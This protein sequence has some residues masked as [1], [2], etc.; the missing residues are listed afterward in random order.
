MDPTPAQLRG[1]EPVVAEI[2]ITMLN[3]ARAQGVP[4]VIVH[5]GGL[6]NQA[7]QA[8]L[9]GMGRSRTRDSA[10]LQGRAFDF[11]VLGIGRDQVPREL[12]QVLG[13]WGEELG[14]T[15]G[16]RWGWDWA[17]FELPK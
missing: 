6:R 12:W 2:A 10:H 13:E 4:L 1:L 8:E 9:L 14:L 17:H 16:G 7:Q 5:L 3:E 15:W 11:D